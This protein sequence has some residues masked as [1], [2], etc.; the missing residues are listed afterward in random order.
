MNVL[1]FLLQTVDHQILYSRMFLTFRGFEM[2][3]SLRRF[4]PKDGLPHA[5]MIHDGRRRLQ[6]QSDTP[7]GTTGTVLVDSSDL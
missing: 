1:C 4:C 2:S 6:S 3:E 5:I 7:V